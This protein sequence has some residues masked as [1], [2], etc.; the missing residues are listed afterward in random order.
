MFKVIMASIIS[1]M[2]LT[3]CANSDRQYKKYKV[4][5]HQPLYDRT[6]EHGQHYAGD[7]NRIWHSH[8]HID[9]NCL[10]YHLW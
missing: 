3:S 10:H 4:T 5:C 6:V 9:N 1:L 2:M 8:W 7:R